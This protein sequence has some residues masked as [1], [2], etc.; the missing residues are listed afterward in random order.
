MTMDMIPKMAGGDSS[1]IR[2]N[3]V[4]LRADSLRLL[5]PQAD[6]RSTE[7]I[8]GA[9]CASAVG[10]V[11]TPV[12]DADSTQTVFALSE[13]MVPLAEFPAGRFLRT[14]LATEAEE[15]SFAWDEV[16][17]L[18]DAEFEQRPLPSVMRVSDALV[19]SYVD[20]DGDLVFC[21][22]ADRL[23]SRAVSCLG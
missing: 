5:L 11:F 2:G 7:Y 14:K 23:I 4:V 9:P 16:R 13:E 3:F 12:D 15:V 22:S 20:L 8:E 21:M 6:V 10:G 17:V 18:I 19:D 1:V